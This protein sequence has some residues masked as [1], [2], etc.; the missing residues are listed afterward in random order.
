MPDKPESMDAALDEAERKAWE[1]LGR[2]KF[3]MFGY[4]AAVWVH[5]NRISGQNRPN[6][7]RQLVSLARDKLSPDA[8]IP[9]KKETS[10]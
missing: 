2:Y 1:A 7:W 10:R 6:P 4:H 3:L 9:T 5:L 8:T